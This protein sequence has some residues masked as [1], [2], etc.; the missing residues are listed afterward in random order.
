[1]TTAM[2]ATAPASARS[3]ITS[4][5]RSLGEPA[6]APVERRGPTR[7][8]AADAGPALGDPTFTAPPAY[9]A[10]ATTLRTDAETR[11]T[12]LDVLA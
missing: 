1:M 5:L 6:A 10:A 4:A 2:I 11:G 3:G 9:G 12:L 7:S 8:S